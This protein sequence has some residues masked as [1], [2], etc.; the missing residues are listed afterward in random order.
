MQRPLLS[1][2][3]PSCNRHRYL[4]PVLST[5]LQETSAEIVVS[6]NSD[7]ELPASTLAS[8]EG[9]SRL[10][11]EHHKEK[12]SVVENFERG[13]KRATGE[14][15][16]FLGDDDCVGPGI[17]NIVRWAKQNQVEAVVSYRHSFIAW[18]FWP[19][20]K[21]RYFGDGYA[22]KM[23]VGSHTGK[24][25]RLDTHAA[26]REAASRPGAGLGRMA[27]AYHGIVSRDLVDRVVAKYGRLFGGVSPDIF[28]ATLLS[29]EARN[30]VIVDHPFVI[31]G[32]SP[33]STAGEG[34]ARKDIDK[35]QGRD[36]IRRFGDSLQWDPRIPAF[37]S[38]ITVWSYSHLLALDL[39][40]DR[41][42]GLNFPAL[43]VRCLMHYRQYRVDILESFGHWRPRAGKATLI[44]AGAR[45]LGGELFSLAK[46]VWF[47]F[48]S[49][50][51]AYAE[52]GTIGDAYMRLKERA[53]TWSQQPV[54]TQ[55]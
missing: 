41:T 52:L 11:Y 34:A 17:E 44:P 38:P 14:F 15:L 13:L 39:L 48:V 20:V 1:I 42:M 50:P 2:V 37:Y 22:G 25:S 4:V 9:G 55:R 3:V 23:F 47:K 19:G 21:S 31:P 18:Y 32:A 53:G 46:R 6:D 7:E 51:Q 40:R 43:Y 33:A 45:V 49:P 10:V 26:I 36:H 5:L 24:V 30:A 54:E 29:Y 27:R 28:S 35:L 8:L 12:L 16:I